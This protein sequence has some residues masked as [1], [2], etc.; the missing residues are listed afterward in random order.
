MNNG[1]SDLVYLYMCGGLTIVNI[2]TASIG[3]IIHSFF[4]GSQARARAE[5]AKEAQAK[6]AQIRHISEMA[7][8]KSMQSEVVM[9]DNPAAGA[10]RLKKGHKNDPKHAPSQHPELATQLAEIEVGGIEKSVSGNW[11]ALL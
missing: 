8:P 1:K 4:Y 3:L 9:Q 2:T 6:Q 5:I 7:A 10:E 11:V